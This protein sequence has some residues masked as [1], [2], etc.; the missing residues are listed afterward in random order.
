[1]GNW[2]D[3][4][5]IDTIVANLNAIALGHGALSAKTMDSILAETLDCFIIIF[6]GTELVSIALSI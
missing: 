4:I 5:L 6:T 1:M 2:K 3:C